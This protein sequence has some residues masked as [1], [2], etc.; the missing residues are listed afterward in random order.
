MIC[1]ARRLTGLS[2]VLLLA[3]PLAGRADAPAPE[4]GCVPCHEKRHPAI[5]SEWRRSRHGLV[6]VSCEA[7]HGAE[8]RGADDAA[9]AQLPSPDTCQHCHEQKALQFKRGMHARAWA[10]VKAIPTFHKL[11]VGG[12]SDP[13]DCAVCHRIG[14]KTPAE[15]A[16][17]IKAGAQHRMASCDACHTRHLFSREEARRPEACRT[18]HGTL[19]FDPWLTSRHGQRALASAVGKDPAGPGAPTCQTCHMQAGDHAVRAPW[20]SL[21]LRVPEEPWDDWG[22]DRLTLLVALGVLTEVGGHGPRYDA[23]EDSL[24]VVLDR[25]QYQNDR[26]KLTGACRQCHEAPFVREQLDQRDAL[27]RQADTLC[28]KAVHEVAALYADGLLRREGPGPW[29]DLV[30][31]VNGQPVERRLSSMFFDHRAKLIAT[32]FHMSS[33]ASTWRAAM[34]QDLVEIE[35]MAGKLRARAKGKAPVKPAAPRPATGQ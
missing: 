31:G 9:Q 1:T 32:A 7:C 30:R 8:H 35:A 10:S 26:L 17:I 13:A 12:S 16:A 4:Q 15:T 29:P 20:G 34:A 27:V 11:G 6:K 3:A 24:V 14:L 18:C 22:R 21:A 19:Q 33:D 5:V 25:I 28:A 2:A 23:A